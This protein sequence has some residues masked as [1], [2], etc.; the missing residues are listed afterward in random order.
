[1]INKLTALTYIINAAMEKGYTQRSLIDGI[2][3]Y[4][5]FNRMCNGKENISLDV[6]LACADKIGLSYNEALRQ[7]QNK[8]YILLE[9]E[10]D[11]VLEFHNYDHLN[12]VYQ[13]LSYLITKKDD[14]CI[15][16]LYYL[17]KAL[18]LWRSNHNDLALD[19]FY[20]A[21][22]ITTIKKDMFKISYHM[23]SHI[24]LRIVNAIA[25][26]EY[27]KG[28]ITLSINILKKILQDLNIYEV[29]INKAKK[30]IESSYFLG[31]IQLHQKNIQ[32]ANFFID[33]GI[34]YSLKISV[35]LYM[36][37]LYYYSAILN[38]LDCKKDKGNILLDECYI[39]AQTQEKV[40]LFLSMLKKDT[41]MYSLNP[42]LS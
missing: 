14:P 20:T 7:P 11:K 18:L 5:H 25:I 17:V 27:L 31:L 34:Q 13:E 35:Y 4:S 1:M 12:T 41:V 26:F 9:D 23:F 30:L 22:H 19:Y 32:E 6:L 10:L 38:Y 39:L 15:K 37:P 3:D 8:A 2:Y 24:E 29:D 16:Q 36:F 21:L 28:N 40:P 33:T 42:E